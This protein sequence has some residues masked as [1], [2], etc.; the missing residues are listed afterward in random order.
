MGRVV[1]MAYG[2]DCTK[3]P[4]T[5]MLLLQNG[6]GICPKISSF[7]LVVPKLIRNLSLAQV[8]NTWK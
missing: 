7:D 8:C 1:Y 2:D 4:P 6:A 3:F 5:A